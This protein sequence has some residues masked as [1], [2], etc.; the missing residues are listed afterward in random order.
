MSLTG[1]GLGLGQSRSLRLT[2]HL[3]QAIGLL[4][5][6]NSEIAALLRFRAQT[7]PF[8]ELHLAR[9]A[10]DKGKDR[11]AVSD[12]AAGGGAG[13]DEER[14]GAAPAG[15]EAHA[16][17]QAGLVLRRAEDM[18]IA[19][20][21]VA[22][23]EPSGWLGQPLADIAAAAG[24]TP[25]KAEAVLLLLQQAEPAGLFARSLAECLR[26]QAAE[27][28]CLDPVMACV[29]ENLELVAQARLQH[30]AGLCGARVEDVAAR[31]TVIRGFDP[32]PG[33][34]FCDDL[35]V[36]VS[37]DLSVA[38]NAGGWTVEVRNPMF[39]AVAIRAP[40]EV[41]GG[42]GLS[43]SERALLQE[44]QWLRRA[45]DRRD[46]T[47]LRV[48]AE[49]VRRQD[50]FL[51]HGPLALRP[52]RLADIALALELHESTVSRVTSGRSVATPRGTIRLR[53]F[54]SVAVGDREDEAAVSATGLREMI[55]QMLA[56]ERPGAPLSDRQ[57]VDRLA[58]QGHVVA[59]RTV[60]KYREQL[61]V[62]GSAERRRRWVVAQ[63]P[64]RR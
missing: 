61:G 26:L 32:K 33:A 19:E 43:A 20:H 25:A 8:L 63:S 42:A 13:I 51:R 54:F 46:R 40:E 10:D 9:P 49:I 60:A 17:Q 7:N 35:R 37:P 62:P 44:A 39:S 16:R 5:M 1:H 6:S 50:A 38:R 64:G 28:G 11:A 45:C 23:L 58:S 12:W 53:D 30:V 52:M 55:R 48:G 31:L 14:L 21:L 4:G 29:L 36:H 59:R 56:G 27:A 2:R 41:A 18:A 57:V 34:R 3:G 24:C 15:L 47:L 22:A